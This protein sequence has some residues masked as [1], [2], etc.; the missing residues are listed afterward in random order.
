[1]T[2]KITVC[3]KHV[4]QHVFHSTECDPFV[5]TS[6][7]LTPISASGI[8]SVSHLFPGIL[9]PPHQSKAPLH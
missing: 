7:F 8:S 9:N 3:N 4:P 2:R 6:N 1:M 5:V